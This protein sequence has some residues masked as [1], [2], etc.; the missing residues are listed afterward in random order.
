MRQSS[1]SLGIA[2]LALVGLVAV[3]GT[4]VGGADRLDFAASGILALLASLY[5]FAG[6]ASRQRA[7]RRMLAPVRSDTQPSRVA[8]RR[9]F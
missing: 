4:T 7:W 8:G 6:L 5:V 3:G 2:A 9:V 1:W